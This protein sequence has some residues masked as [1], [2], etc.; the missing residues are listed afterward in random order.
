MTRAFNR[1][2]LEAFR[3]SPFLTQYGMWIMNNVFRS[4]LWMPACLALVWLLAPCGTT[5]QAQTKEFFAIDKILQDYATVL[6]GLG[7]VSTVNIGNIDCH[8]SFVGAMKGVRTKLE[9]DLAARQIA[10]SSAADHD[11]KGEFTPEPSATE[12]GLNGV[13]KFTLA[14]ALGDDPR[15][16]QTYLL[17]GEKDLGPLL[18]VTAAGGSSISSEI[19]TD[20]VKRQT[21]AEI[22]DNVVYARD[23]AGQ[24]NTDYGV[25]ILRYPRNGDATSLLDAKMDNGYNFVDIPTDTD[26]AI[27][28]VNKSR[29]AAAVQVSID[30]L[31]QFQYVHDE[32]RDQT[33]QP[34]VPPRYIIPAG[35]TT[36][37]LG[38]WRNEREVYR[39]TVSGDPSEGAAASHLPKATKLPDKLGLVCVQFYRAW[40][41]DGDVPEGAVKDHEFLLGSKQTVPGQTEQ[42]A[43]KLEPWLWEGKEQAIISIRYDKP[44]NK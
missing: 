42:S 13:F 2:S 26:Y 43:S 9:Q 22:R 44:D 40:K 28:I 14:T 20:K 6:A 31:S 11:V 19:V 12:Q 4:F 29:Y 34:K 27:R 25:A 24:T 21:S 23:K 7:D 17:K 41:P 1:F 10:V 5:A 3:L 37:I 38:W 36:D 18:G 33:G 35:T 16:R 8:S 32:Y 39:F 15:A 30:G